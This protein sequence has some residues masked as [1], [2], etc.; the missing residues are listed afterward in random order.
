MSV[1][2]SVCKVCQ[3]MARLYQVSIGKEA[4]LMRHTLRLRDD[5]CFASKFVAEALCGRSLPSIG[6]STALPPLTGY[7]ELDEEPATTHSLAELL[8]SSRFFGCEDLCFSAI[9]DDPMHCGIGEL[10]L[11]RI[12][13]H[14]PNA[15]IA[16]AMAGGAAGILT[17]QLLPCPLPQCIVGNIDRALASLATV[18]NERPDQKLL[19]IGV[20]G[21]SGKTSTCLMISAL[22]TASGLRTAYQC[23]LGSHE[24]VTASTPNTPKAN[25][26]ALV[27]WLGEAV[28]CCS[29][30]A[31]IE[32]DETEARHGSYD[33]INFDILV[34]TQRD[35]SDSDFGPSALQAMI[36]RLTDAGIVVVNQT[37]SKSQRLLDRHE[38]RFVTY[39]TQPDA[40]FAALPVRSDGG[41]TTLMIAADQ[42]S[43]VME[44]PLCGPAM[45]R[46]FAA[47]SA[48][49]GMLGFTPEAIAQRMQ[50]L[51]S[52]PGRG[53]RMSEFGKPI[54]VIESGGAVDRVRVSLMAAKE[55]GIGGRVWCVCTLDPNFDESTLA[56][57]G[58]ALERHAHH[59]VLSAGSN[60]KQ[61]LSRSHQLLD[62][63]KQCASMRLVANQEQAVRW[64]MANAAPRDTVV[65]VLNSSSPSAAQERGEIEA[66][67]SL[68]EQCWA[69]RE[70]AETSIE[71][72]DASKIKLKLF[73]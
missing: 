47:A 9:A 68:V 35:S 61:F 72:G 7:R 71:P 33:E 23:D 25:G 63:V 69:D 54:A 62:G 1:S 10:V 67:K 11:C 55:A 30:V 53:E 32:I 2:V 41:M 8:P 27:E 48:V 13:E 20:L 65:I 50:R 37:D 40:D 57:I 38:I 22:T 52:I 70:D 66:T 15:I 39:G 56:S 44:T 17:E 19:T 16:A 36:D 31:V 4:K 58:N 64:A 51:R 28:D 49:G 12:G 18:R 21:A 73:P 5:V 14:D 45:A 34:V 46:N 26:A 59:T 60:D 43:A 42:T 6:Q 3:G 29:R 24:G